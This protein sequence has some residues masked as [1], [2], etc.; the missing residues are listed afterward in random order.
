MKKIK[1]SIKKKIKT[2]TKF[3]ETGD[4]TVFEGHGYPLVYIYKPY[5]KAIR[6][7]NAPRLKIFL[8]F[9]LFFPCDIHLMCIHLASQEKME[10][11]VVWHF[12]NKTT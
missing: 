6:G 8:I 12:E 1:V 10:K 2:W 3:K 4:F 9:S 7:Y 5:S 11:K